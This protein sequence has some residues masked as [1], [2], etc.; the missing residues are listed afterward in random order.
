MEVSMKKVLYS[1]LLVVALM[2]AYQTMEATSYVEIMANS[3]ESEG[4]ASSELRNDIMAKVG[5]LSRRFEILQKNM[6][7]VL[8]KKLDKSL[9][10]AINVLDKA[11]KATQRKGDSIRTAQLDQDVE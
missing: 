11:V 5:Q 7:H 2:S 10:N 6:S 1:S 9:D 4:E 8:L 3:A